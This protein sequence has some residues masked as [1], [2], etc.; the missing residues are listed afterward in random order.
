VF[1]L[2][3][4]RREPEI[5][6]NKSDVASV[7]TVQ[8]LYDENR[9]LD[10]F[11]ESAEY[12][13]PSTSIQNLSVDE[14]ILGGRLAARLGGGR[15][16]RRLLRTAYAR[17]PDNP[18]VRLFHD[19]YP[20]VQVASARQPAGVREKSGPLPGGSGDASSMACFPCGHLGIPPRFHKRSP[21]SR[22]R[23][24]SAKPARVG[25]HM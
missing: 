12:W 21:L 2:A 22:A 19:E 17:E 16:S 6:S 10:A 15:L 11:R 5:M 14:L 3:I 13:K 25:D 1:N 23:P 4:L 8:H 9:F 20:P 7:R 18:R 24:Q